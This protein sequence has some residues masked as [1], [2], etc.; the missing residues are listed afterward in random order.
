MIDLYTWTT[1]NGVKISIALEE[2]GLDYETHA[3]NIGKDEQFAPDFLKISP[4]N[5]IPAIYDRQTGR[6]VFESGAILIYLAEKTGKFMPSDPAAR[7]RVLE[8]LMWQMGGFG[9]ML[10]QCHHFHRFNPGKAPYAEE[11]YLNETRRLYGVLDKRL[12]EAAYPGG[13]EMTIA[14]FAIWPWAARAEWQSVALDD[15]P[16]VARWYRELAARPGFIRGY[17]KP[18]TGREVPAL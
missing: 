1:P 5:K 3:I 6:S 14:D 11:R 18:E 15:F 9:P 17:D 7:I 13:D 8:W 12:G 10:G 2:M 16:N 4:N